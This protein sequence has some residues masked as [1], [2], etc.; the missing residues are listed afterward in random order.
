M[1]GIENIIW[2]SAVLPLERGYA[3]TGKIYFSNGSTKTISYYCNPEDYYLYHT[4]FGYVMF[5]TLKNLLRYVNIE[6]TS[7][8]LSLL[9]PPTDTTYPRWENEGF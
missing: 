6:V 5:D 2:N 7:D 1:N 8:E 9:L 4:F 3:V